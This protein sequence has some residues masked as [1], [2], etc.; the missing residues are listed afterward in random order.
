M[1]YRAD[2]LMID[3]HTDTDTRRQRQYP[4]AETGLGWKQDERTFMDRLF[5]AW[6]DCFL[7]PTRHGGMSVSNNTETNAWRDFHEI[8]NVDRK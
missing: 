4:K 3:E 5:N 8:S 6:L 7:D 1:N 2:K